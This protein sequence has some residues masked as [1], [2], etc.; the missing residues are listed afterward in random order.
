MM[1]EK[2]RRQSKLDPDD[3]FDLPPRPRHE[4]RPGTSSPDSEAQ[5]KPGGASAGESPTESPR[6]PDHETKRDQPK[7][8]PRRRPRP[9]AP[10]SRNPRRLTVHKGVSDEDMVSFNCKMSRGLR[11]AVRHYAADVEVDIQDVV[12]AALVDYLQAR[13]RD[14]PA[15]EQR[16][17]D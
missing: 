6:P 9:A 5:A 17:P 14:V 2:P 13:D 8:P 7:P 10:V 12:A 1:V 4:D 15:F 16:Q 3:P 11:R